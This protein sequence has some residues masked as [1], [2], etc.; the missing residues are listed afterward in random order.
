MRV[1]AYSE[2]TRHVV[3]AGSFNRLTSLSRFKADKGRPRATGNI[4]KIEN[5]LFDKKKPKRRDLIVE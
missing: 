4:E 3:C 1:Y 2:P 5:K